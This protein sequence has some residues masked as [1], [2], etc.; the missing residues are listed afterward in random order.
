MIAAGRHNQLATAR[1]YAP[2]AQPTTTLYGETRESAALEVDQQLPGWHPRQPC[3]GMFEPLGFCEL[4]QS[5]AVGMDHVDVAPP[6]ES[7]PGPVGRPRRASGNFASRCNRTQ[8]GAIPVRDVDTLVDTPTAWP[9]EPAERNSGT[10]GR[11]RWIRVPPLVRALREPRQVPGES[12]RPVDHLEI[13]QRVRR[14]AGPFI[15]EGDAETR[16]A[17]L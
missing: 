7:D 10:V 14:L 8:A 9:R 13:R 5:R 1:A 17:R 6:H 11:P 2:L 15:C 3:G 16:P 12:S 4:V